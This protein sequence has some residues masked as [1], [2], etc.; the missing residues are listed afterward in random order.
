MFYIFSSVSPISGNEITNVRRI[1]DETSVEV[2]AIDNP[3]Y[4][5]WVEAGNTAEEWAAPPL[6]E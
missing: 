6:G 1:I 3:A 2:M 4:L 5:A